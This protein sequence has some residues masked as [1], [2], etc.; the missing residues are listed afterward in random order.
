ML[1]NL[2]NHPSAAWS[3]AQLV[4]ARSRFGEKIQDL[5]HPEIPPE[6]G[7]EEVVQLAE[8]YFEKVIALSPKAV[9]IM[10][11]QTFCFALIQKLLQAGI[12]C[13]AS[14]TRRQV[15][16]LSDTEIRRSF[17]FVRFREYG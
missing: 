17:V 11:E 2:S 8:A 12:P 14:T 7:S 6:A 3:E 5:P 4:A 13:Y 10:G 9:H 15:E 1:L 16:H